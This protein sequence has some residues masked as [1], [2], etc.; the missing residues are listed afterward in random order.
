MT[1]QRLGRAAAAAFACVIALILGVGNGY[2]GT[3]KG[4]ISRSG[5]RPKRAKMKIT[6]DSKVCGKKPIYDPT[7]IVDKNNG[8]ANAV[9]SIE[10]VKGGKKRAKP[11]TLKLDQSGCEYKPHVAATTTGSKVKVINSDAT[12]HNIHAFLDGDTVF[13]IAMP[14]EGQKFTKELDE[15]GIVLFKC[16]AGHTWMSAYFLV[17]DHPYFAV[18][19]KDGSFSIPDVPEG[20]YKVTIWHEKLGEKTKRVTVEDGDTVFDF[21]Y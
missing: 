1:T 20:S 11:R 5:E 6:Q 12:L 9:V 17:F 13:N 16:D 18:T 3:V 4:K 19:K 21:S 7:L 8:L 2:A 15:A 10:K 14:V